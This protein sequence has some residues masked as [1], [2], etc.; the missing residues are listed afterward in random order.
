MDD[1]ERDR[2][3][4]LLAW[5]A[6]A[7]ERACAACPAAVS[8]RELVICHALGYRNA[9]RC[10]DCLAADLGRERGALLAHVREYILHRAC[11]RAGW[12][13]AEAHGEP[14]MNQEQDWDA[15]DMGCGDLVLELRLKLRAMAPGQVLRVR[16]TDPG[17]PEDLPAWCG[18]TGH[19]LLE[20]KHPF[21]RIRRKQET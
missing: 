7:G 6:A 8:P 16:A 2:T 1:R 12:E 19:T 5:L 20:S 9:P 21:Y 13:W 10:A 18:M 17:A 4:A 11:Y 3:V 14:S 15:G